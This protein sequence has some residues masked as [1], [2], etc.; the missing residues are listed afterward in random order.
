[1]KKRK[2][3][4]ISDPRNEQ[5][6]K[7]LQLEIK[8]SGLKK[9][10]FIRIQGVLLRKQGYARNEIAKITGKSIEALDSVVTRPPTTVLGI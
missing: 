4:Y 10:E 7:E 1:M 8:R 2:P 5:F 9:D 3:T 6:I